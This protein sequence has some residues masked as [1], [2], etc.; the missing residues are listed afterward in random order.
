MG[1]SPLMP[2]HRA[3]ERDE[4]AVIDAEGVANHA[5]RGAAGSLV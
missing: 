2:V 5:A 3:L 1:W 4:G